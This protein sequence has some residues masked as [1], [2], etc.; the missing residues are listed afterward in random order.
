MRQNLFGELS[1]I[2]DTV[3]KGLTAPADYA[4]QNAKLGLEEKKL[5]FDIGQQKEESERKKKTFDLDL[6]EAEHKAALFKEEEARANAPVRA[7]D[8]LGDSISGLKFGY[9]LDKDGMTNIDKIK[10]VTGTIL[11]TD[12]F[13]PTAGAFINAKTGKAMTQR[14][15]ERFMPQVDMILEANADPVK[16]LKMTKE[17]IDDDLYRGKI[18]K[19]EHAA[20]QKEVKGYDNDQTHLKAYEAKLQRL[21]RFKGTEA[22]LARKRTEEKIK[23]YRDKI[24]KTETRKADF[25]DKK[26]LLDKEIAAGKYAKTPEKPEM[27]E[28]K[29]REELFKLAKWE[30]QLDKTGGMDDMLFAMIAKDNPD[31]AGKMQGADKTEAKKFIN[32]Q[33][34]YYKGFLTAN[35]TAKDLGGG[36]SGATHVYIP[37]QGIVLKNPK[38]QR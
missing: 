7:T 32:E 33:R 12:E 24:D 25:A 36:G 19:E 35:K 29:A 6:P 4:L 15:F 21:A 38:G 2:G 5:G 10:Q 28:P 11:D 30:T 34:N 27:N 17:N 13:S 37:G 18:T 22:E 8:I 31:L 16:F 9:S 20:L 14:E 1:S 26:K 3:Y 23:I